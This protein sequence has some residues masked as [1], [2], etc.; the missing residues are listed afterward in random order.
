MPPRPKTILLEHFA[1]EHRTDKLDF[2]W[3]AR[4]QQSLWRQEQGLSAGTY[5]GK[6][7]GA[8][9]VMPLA[10]KSLAN[11]LTSNIR[12]VVR[13]E[14]EDPIKAKGKL[15]G[16]PRIY[17]NL[18]SSQPLCFNLFAELKR[19]LSLATQ[20]LSAITE[21]RVTA[22][23]GIEFEYSPG[24]GDERYTGDRSAFDVY[25][26]YQNKVGGEGFIGIEV[27]YH[28]GL[29]DPVADHRPR[30]DEL[31]L[32]MGCFHQDRIT[33]LKQKPLQQIWRDHLL[34]GS[35]RL[36]DNFEDGFFVF[37]YPK[38]NTACAEA[39]AA[40]TE[41]L[42]DSLSF[43]PWTLEQFVE[44]LMQHSESDWI[45]SFWNRYLDFNRLDQ[46]IH[47]SQS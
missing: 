8:R 42:N 39:V 18:L 35:H 15:Y 33:R 44:I 22:V 14:V 9:L 19:D 3:R 37:L 32:E 20:V 6:I 2:Q 43:V 13:Q 17:D 11:Y 4:L 5:R 25:V 47:S 27:K 21:G 30:Y 24:R 41:C 46:L 36:V 38:D 7:R 28:E 23:T 40:Y 16:R 12:E 31:A 45:K 1:W 29:G 34:V 26:R 10:Q